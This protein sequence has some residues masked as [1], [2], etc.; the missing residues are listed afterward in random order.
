MIRMVPKTKGGS[1]SHLLFFTT[2]PA[3]LAVV[4]FP[5]KNPEAYPGFRNEHICF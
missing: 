3:F 5:A 2:F 4:S 1:L